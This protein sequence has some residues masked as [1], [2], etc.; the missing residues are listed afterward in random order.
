MRT[1]K[2]TIKAGALALSLVG[3]L[4]TGTNALAQESDTPEPTKC[5]NID[6]TSISNNSFLIANPIE[7][8]YLDRVSEGAL[9]DTLI[10][11]NLGNDASLRIIISR[12]GKD[13]RFT[14]SDNNTPSEQI[15][16]KYF[17]PDSS[18]TFGDGPV[19][20]HLN[21]FDGSGE[22][23]LEDCSTC[24]DCSDTKEI[25]VWDRVYNTISQGKFISGRVDSLNC[26]DDSNDTIMSATPI[27]KLMFVNS[28]GFSQDT[29]VVSAMMPCENDYYGNQQSNDFYL[30]GRLS[31]GAIREA[32]PDSI[33]TPIDKAIEG[34][35]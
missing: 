32:T 25:G 6:S 2:N 23:Y 1:I 34:L 19:G 9:S 3:A 27:Y 28:D 12:E 30:N 31:V 4:A 21:D 20:V 15:L 22:V 16:R 24:L 26:F 5:T 10:D 33:N 18:G 7:R 17:V 13:V 11:Q 14:Y 29:V 35:K 8:G